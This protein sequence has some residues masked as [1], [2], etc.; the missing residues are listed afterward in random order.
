MR[1]LTVGC[2]ALL[3]FLLTPIVA[4]AQT[5]T[6]S[7]TVRDSSGGVLPG[8]TV[9]A[10]SPALIEK[11]RSTVTSGS[12]SYSIVALRPGTY[13]VKFE[14]PGFSTVIR[15]GI[16]LTSDFTATINIDLKVGAL[17]ETLT[18]T[19]ESPIVD[20]RSITQR[21][22]MTAEVR[23]AL[24]TGRNIQAVG[25]MIPGTT[26]AMGG[27]GALSRDVGGS[28]NLQ[29]SPLQYR[30]SGDT[31]QTVDGIRLN[32]LCAQGAYSGVYWNDA[33]F[34]E[35]SYVTGADSTE[36]GQGGMRVNMVPRDGGNTFRGSVIFN[37]AG[38]RFGSDNCGSPGLGQACSRSN[39]SGSKTFNANNHIT[40]VDVIKEI[41][42]VNPSIGGPIKRNKIWFNYTFRNL[43]STKTK[44]DAYEDRNP[45]PFI[46]DP[47]FSKPGVDDGHITSNAGRIS[48]QVSSRDK[49]SV[50]HDNQRK[51]RNHW[52]IAA[53][54]PPDAAGVQ[55]TPTSFVNVSKW[56]RTHTNNL[57]LEAG[58]GMYNQEYT[59]LYQ[60]SVVGHD[61][62]VWDEEAI[63]NSRVYNVVD[64]SN[65]RQANAW[66]NPAD[67]FS[68]LRTFMGAA[69]YVLGAHSFRG[70][71]TWSNGDWRE[72]RMWTGDVQPITFNAGRP[73]SV[74]LRLPNDRAN[75]IN[76]DL[77]IYAQDKWSLGRVTL[78]LGVRY[79]QFIGETRESK[80][81]PSRHGAGATFGD[82]P[83]GQWDP[84]EL[85]TGKVQNWK[86]LSPRVGF[87]MDVFGN[88]RTAIK[89][90]W[91]RYVA[92]QNIAFVNQVNPIGALTAADTRAWTDLDGNGLPI[93]ANGNIQFNELTNSAATSTFGR[94]TVPTTTYSPDLLRGWGKRGY[95][96]E[97]TVAAQHQLADRISV[98]GGYYR[99][100]FGNQVIFDDLRYDESSYDY[101]CLR[102]P[103]DPDLP[104]GG[105]Y[106]VCGIPDLKQSVFA[107]N[108]PANTLIR[109]S[110]DFGG[111]TNL[112][113]GFDVNLEARFRNGAFL[114]GGIAATSRT[115][116]NCNLLKAGADAVA[117]GS[118]EIYP[119]SKG[120]HRE[121][122]YRP[123]AK[124]SASYTLPWDI[125]V[126]GT[127]QFTR[128]VQTGGAGPSITAS[129]TVVNAVAQ[130][131]LGRNWQ[132]NAASRTVQLISE[133]KDYG[134]HNLNQ[135]DIRLGK[136]FNVNRVRLRV[137]F[138][139]YNVLNSSWPYT[140]NTIYTTAAT[141]SYL[142][143]TNVLQHRF[144]KLGGHIS[145]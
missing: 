77:G 69:N 90:S 135:L 137:D 34:E 13:T 97:Y 64:S 29:Q 1:L 30:G 123:D 38:E 122:G 103:S 92:G 44:T 23:E 129:W 112:F 145:F 47:D 51:Y 74:T 104:G 60:P 37:F 53:T 68:V 127:Y 128:G 67:H 83:D 49:V 12:G 48:W 15:E 81:L 88:G 124:W 5:S 18:V 71:V 86:D 70:G 105:G 20:T 52:G 65:A 59:E 73:T 46:Y 63:R 120:C 66:P 138:D 40:N 62:K 33:S 119:D 136:R 61:R 140:V 72:L 121:Y 55:V 2:F 95:N 109:F 87:A 79:D 126:A 115:F 125:Q 14:L 78:N 42:D 45:S 91:A 32:N 21:V 133:G 43:G 16:E 84:G 102:A 118:N 17:E 10:S 130:Q 108:Q 22:V 28:G 80:V 4:S 35:F 36:M 3:T 85:C 57:L 27:G 25:I 134:K 50:Y 141:S 89:A 107:L 131:Q 113:Q 24:P 143:P 11:A 9:E 111:E 82:C 58:F 139:L 19:G 117:A 110:K 8:V 101:V 116:D 75:G 94:L 99:R 142:R 31:V 7:G 144:F 132:S 41:W 76:R 106:Q 39:L 96:N 114:R 26:I 100:K 93:D 98:N 56:T 54:V 6:I